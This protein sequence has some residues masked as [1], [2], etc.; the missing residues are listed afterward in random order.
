MHAC[1]ESSIKDQVLNSF[2]DPTSVLRVVIATVAFGMGLDCP[3]FRKLFH[4]GQPDNIESYLQ[5]TGRAGWDG[6]ASFV[7]LF[8]KL[9][10]S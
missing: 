8:F 3:N 5:E 4:W 10:G 6:L 7:H 1:T 2:R 9:K